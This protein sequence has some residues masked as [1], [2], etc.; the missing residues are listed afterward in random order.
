[1]ARSISRC[2]SSDSWPRT[3]ATGG[4]RTA[5]FERGAGA[6]RSYYESGQLLAEG[7]FANGRPTGTWTFYHP[8]G[9]IS[10]RGPMREGRRHG[11]WTFHYDDAKH[12]RL[13][14]GRFEHGE[15][16]N[17]WRHYR[18]D[19]TLLA[20]SRG[21][22]NTGNFMSLGVERDRDGIERTVLIGRQASSERRD[23]FTRGKLTLELENRE[24][25]VDAKGRTLE[26]RAGTW[27][28]ITCDAEP[29]PDSC[30]EPVSAELAAFIAKV[31]AMR[32]RVNTRVPSVPL[33]AK[34][35]KAQSEVGIVRAPR[36]SPLGDDHRDDMVTY[37][38][39][40]MAWF[41]EWPHVDDAFR[42][43]YRTLPIYERPAGPRG[44]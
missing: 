39:E 33:L 16:A 19:G 34:G 40:N 28:A 12:T 32:N 44:I 10:A 13:S 18:P 29:T 27:F 6:W 14:A 5:A 25:L 42:A 2:R 9:R 21:E 15:L 30:R 23:L 43:V 11:A 31:H 41:V 1:M 35:W 38:S 24:R 22:V 26:Y 20:T 36:G 4:P 3:A 8:S 7:T 37:L 17:P